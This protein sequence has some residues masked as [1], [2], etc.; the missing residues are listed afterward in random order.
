[1]KLKLYDSFIFLEGWNVSERMY[2]SVC[3]FVEEISR[4]LVQDLHHY[5]TTQV[6]IRLPEQHHKLHFL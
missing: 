5:R 2:V 4:S 1:M 6:E 3:L